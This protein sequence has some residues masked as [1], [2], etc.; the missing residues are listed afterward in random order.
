MATRKGKRILGVDPPALAANRVLHSSSG[1]LGKTPIPPSIS[2]PG[3]C[4]AGSA[5]A[6]S[7]ARGPVKS[8]LDAEQCAQVSHDRY[9]RVSSTSSSQIDLETQQLC[10]FYSENEDQLL[11]RFHSTLTDP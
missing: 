9:G 5:A 3:I 6:D 4:R 11:A 1:T 7:L 2:V 8:G 10:Q